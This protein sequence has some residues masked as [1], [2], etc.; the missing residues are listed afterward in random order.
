MTG[1]GRT[2]ELFACLKS[3]TVPDLI[4]LSKGLSGGCLPLAV[5][6]A[7]EAFYNDDVALAFYHGH[8]YT[9]NP[10]ACATGIV[11]YLETWHH[12]YLQGHPL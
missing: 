8:S 6:L 11:S 5:T 7:S 1:F 4:C 3:E 12:Q 2:G 10:L 9:G